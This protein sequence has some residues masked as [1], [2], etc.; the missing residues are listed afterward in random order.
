MGFTVRQDDEIQGFDFLDAIGSHA[1]AVAEVGS[2]DG[3]QACAGGCAAAG[4]DGVED[5]LDFVRGSDVQVCRGVGGVE[6]VDIDAVTVVLG[7]DRGDGLEGV[8]GLAP[9]GA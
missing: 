5:L 3:V 7:A 4:L 1:L 2:Q 8:A 9:F 6:E